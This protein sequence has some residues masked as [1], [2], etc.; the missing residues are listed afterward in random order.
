MVEQVS[1]PEGGESPEAIAAAT[2]A[3]NAEM[4][5]IAESGKVIEKPAEA[6]PEGGVEKFFDKDKGAYNWEAHAKDADFRSGQSDADKL[7]AAE[8]AAKPGTEEVK[9]VEEA[10]EV[11][12]MDLS[13]FSQEFADK[14][15][16]AE[17][18]YTKLAEGGF[19][20]DLVDQFIAGQVAVAA[21][22]RA[23]VFSAIGG[24]KNFNDMSK[25]AAESA[26]PEDLAVY[27][28][29]VGLGDTANAK[30]AVEA[31][32]SRFTEA[33]G[34]NPNLITADGAPSSGA[35][36]FRSWEEVRVAMA[37]KRYGAD[38]AYTDDL[39]ARLDR[40]NI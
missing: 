14:G 29:A 23:E 12:G 32:Y 19:P 31:L 20:K 4:V 7:K 30:M 37:D 35:A 36:A 39:V 33:A 2:A 10:L 38:S 21:A 25:W 24:E 40:S 13:T 1:I 8:A 16:L 26:T 17:E 22:T 28:K 15:E 18:S 5:K 34:K 9:K 27:N 11:K 3:H 6:M